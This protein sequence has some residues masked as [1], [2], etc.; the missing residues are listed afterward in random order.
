MRELGIKEIFV[1]IHLSIIA[2]FKVIAS[3]LC[4]LVGWTET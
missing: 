2:T 4:L 1:L 3:D